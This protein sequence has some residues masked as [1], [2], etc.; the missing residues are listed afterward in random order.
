[1]DAS[2][3]KARN[4]IVEVT[5]GGRGGPYAIGIMN[6]EQAL[7]LPDIGLLSYTHPDP[8][9]AARG[10]VVDRSELARFAQH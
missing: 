1:M 10:V 3:E 4:Y 7:S 9:K 5:A 8:K 6:V 2:R